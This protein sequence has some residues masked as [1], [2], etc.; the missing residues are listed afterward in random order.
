MING[1]SSFNVRPETKADWNKIQNPILVLYVLKLSFPLLSLN[2]ISPEKEYSG[3]TP[4]H[5][6]PWNGLGT[7]NSD[8][9]GDKKVLRARAQKPV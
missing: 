2:G 5:P 8:V 7:W 9:D 6:I 1:T 4:H 3:V